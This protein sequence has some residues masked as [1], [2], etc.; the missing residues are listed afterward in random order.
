MHSVAWRGWMGMFRAFETREAPGGTPS[1]VLDLDE[2]SGNIIGRSKI[3]GN[4]SSSVHRDIYEYGHPYTYY[5]GG[6][7]R[8]GLQLAQLASVHSDDKTPFTGE[9]KEEHPHAHPHR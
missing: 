5:H 9:E 7:P 4:G 2:G 6:T 8:R 1:N 3:H